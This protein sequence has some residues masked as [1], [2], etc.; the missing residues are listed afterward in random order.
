MDHVYGIVFWK[1]MQVGSG[2]H[3]IYTER[4]LTEA[5]TLL[6]LGKLGSNSS[7][8]VRHL[9]LPIMTLPYPG[10]PLKYS[11]VIPPKLPA[12]G[13]CMLFP[14]PQQP[15]PISSRE[16]ECATFNL[17]ERLWVF[18]SEEITSVIWWGSYWLTR[19]NC[20]WEKALYLGCRKSGDVGD[21]GGPSRRTLIGWTAGTLV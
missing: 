21:K 6:R 18:I 4:H 1:R 3:H 16:R 13:R 20:A 10:I 5:W 17:G 7:T 8:S 14:P 19:S 2:E 11:A 9:K 15:P 12:L